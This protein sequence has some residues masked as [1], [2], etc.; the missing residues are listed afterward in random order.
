MFAFVAGIAVGAAA[1]RLLQPRS[2]GHRAARAGRVSDALLVL[3]VRAALGHFTTHP[4]SIQVTAARARVTLRGAVL[5]GERAD[6]VAAVQGVAGVE[7]VDDRLTTYV[8][9][10][11]VPSLQGGD[12]SVGTSTS[13]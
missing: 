2:D 13:E 4:K 3:R 7:A 1:I 6:L 9:A 10:I 11:G 5:A 8:D 12:R